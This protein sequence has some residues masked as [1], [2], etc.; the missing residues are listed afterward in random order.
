MELMASLAPVIDANRPPGL[1]RS[2]LSHCPPRLQRDAIQAAWLAVAEGRKPD[3]AVRA[4]LR[5]E[6]R[7]KAD[8]PNF[9]LCPRESVRR[10]F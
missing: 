10:R 5:H 4:L 2:A 7:H 6:E 8:K 3:S 1:S 9:D